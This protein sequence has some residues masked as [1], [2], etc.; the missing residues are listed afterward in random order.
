VH[1][2]QL[3][4]GIWDRKT[5]LNID[6]NDIKNNKKNV[7]EKYIPKKYNFSNKNKESSEFLSIEQ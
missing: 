7:G 3:D 1:K 4:K 2:Q 5:E 6:I